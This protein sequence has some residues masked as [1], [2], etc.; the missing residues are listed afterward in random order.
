MDSADVRSKIILKKEKMKNLI[1]IFLLIASTNLYAQSGIE[2]DALFLKYEQEY[3]KFGKSNLSEDYEQANKDFNSKY[4]I[5][6]NILAFKSLNNNWD[7]FNSIPLEIKSASN[8]IKL[9][10]LIGDD[11]ASSVKD[12]YPNPNGTITFEWYNDQDETVFLEIGNST[13]SYYVEYN[14]IE[15]KYFNKKIINEENS[16]LLSTFI[17]AI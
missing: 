10:D 7:G 16:K 15:T 13:F 1:Y 2:N 4:S 5:I 12:Y 14:S 8:A 9:L 17:K 6:E 11:T 3:L